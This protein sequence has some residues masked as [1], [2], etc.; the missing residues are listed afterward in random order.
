MS[1][2]HVLLTPPPP[3]THQLVAYTLTSCAKTNLH[4]LIIDFLQCSGS[5][6]P[7]PDPDPFIRSRLW[8]LDPNPTG[9]Y[10]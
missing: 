6:A 1:S 9:S 4:W 3:N 10:I 2:L 5:G 8:I 7:G